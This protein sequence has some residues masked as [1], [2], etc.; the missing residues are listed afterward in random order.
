VREPP[1]P[2]G[3]T[4]KLAPA[5]RI[6]LPLVAVTVKGNVPARLPAVV[7]RRMVVDPLPFTAA[8]LKVAVTPAGAPLT[9][10][11]TL[12][13]KPFKAPTVTV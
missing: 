13:P 3:L 4:I 10:N 2:A 9:V 8:G 12:P 6:K 7:A 11:P 5:V 1:A